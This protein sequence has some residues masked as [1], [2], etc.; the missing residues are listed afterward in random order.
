MKLIIQN[1][2]DINTLVNNAG[3]TSDN[4]FLRMKSDQWN[5]VIN[6]NLNSNFY[7]N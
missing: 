7:I 3:I 6:I 5:N 2:K 4:L 1:H